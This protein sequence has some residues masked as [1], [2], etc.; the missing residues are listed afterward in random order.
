MSARQIHVSID[1]VQERI[2]MCARLSRRMG[3]NTK[4]HIGN[5]AA[6]R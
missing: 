1:R 5:T 4:Q 3:L 6:Q 2:F